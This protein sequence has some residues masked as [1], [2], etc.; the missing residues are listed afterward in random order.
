MAFRFVFIITSTNMKILLLR[1]IYLIY[2]ITNYVERKESS[3]QH[4]D[5]TVDE[6]TAN[7]LI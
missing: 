2:L 3:A 7:L 4:E 1:N 5:D 6:L